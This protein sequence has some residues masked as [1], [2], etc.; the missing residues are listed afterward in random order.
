MPIVRKPEMSMS[1]Q[2]RARLAKLGIDNTEESRMDA[3]RQASDL[4]DMYSYVLPPE[5]TL[6]LDVLA[7]FP[8]IQTEQNA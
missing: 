5:T 4:A 8:V 7:G 1:E 2:V 6:P 3:L